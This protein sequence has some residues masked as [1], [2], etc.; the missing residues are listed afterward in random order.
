MLTKYII[1]INGNDYELHP[2]DLRNWDEISCTY[3]RADI[4]GIV[5]S[6]MSK[7]EFVNRAYSLIM[8]AYDR[9]GVYAK[10]KVSIWVINNRWQYDKEF[11]CDLDFSTLQYTER[12]VSISAIDQDIN[13]IIKANKSTKYEMVVGEDVVANGQKFLFDRLKMTETS[14]YAISDGESQEDGSLWGKYLVSNNERILVGNTGKEICIGG[15]IHP[16]D[17][18][19]YQNGCMFYA[20]KDATITLDFSINVSIEKGC[21]ALGLMK[22]DTQICTLHRSVSAYPPYSVKMYES[23]SEV[24]SEINS[25]VYVR[26]DWANNSWLGKWVNINGTIW[27]VLWNDGNEWVNTGKTKK[28]Y[29]S[30]KE[31]GQVTFSVVAGDKVWLKFWAAEDREYSILESELKFSWIARGSNVEIPCIAPQDLLERLLF[32]MGVYLDCHISNYDTR[33]KDCVLLPAESIRGIA[34]ARIYASFDDFCKWME[35][36]FGYTYL[37]S[38]DMIEFKHRLEIFRYDAPIVEVQSHRDIDYTIDTSVLYSSVVIGYEKREYEGVNGRDEF[39]M[40]STYTTDYTNNGKKLELKSPFRA[41]S[42][43]IEFLCQKRGETTTDNISDQDIFFAT[44]YDVGGYLKPN[45]NPRIENSVTGTLINGEFSPIRCVH[46][47]REYISMMSNTLN[48]TFASTDGNSDIIIDDVKMSDPITCESNEMLTPG[49][50]K[51]TSDML[52]LPGDV[53]SIYR[54]KTDDAIY[55]GYLQEVTFK[56]GKPEKATYKLMIKYKRPC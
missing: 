36:V 38:E 49:V 7:F 19:E 52:S 34:G 25:D 40:S 26:N 9:E 5:R 2:D 24:M 54:V 43:G 16:N 39:N 8:D 3:K 30:N 20:L 35:T 47:N 4:G 41:D 56:Y 48:L 55:E 50:L 23:I 42:Y 27:E 11:T 37:V 21:G 46:A 14:T 13:A 45:R 44:G 12:M 18:Q 53:N 51:F 22:N 32:K 10:A 15:V 1:T 6:F 31:A 28:D 17:D 33:V 29:L